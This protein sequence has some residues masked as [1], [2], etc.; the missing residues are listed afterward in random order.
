MPQRLPHPPRSKRPQNV[1]MRYQHDIARG[2]LLL[3]ALRVRHRRRM[4]PLP[5]LGDQLVA[6]LRHVVRALAVR[7][8]VA[9]DIPFRLATAGALLVDG[10]GGDALIGAVVP[11]L[12]VRARFRLAGDRVREEVFGALEAG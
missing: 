6:P 10:G 11:F 7:A 2:R 12:D 9:P 5:D 8:A 1:P 3:L 4:E